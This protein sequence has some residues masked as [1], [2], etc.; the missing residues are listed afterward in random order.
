M[1]FPELFTDSVTLTYGE[2]IGD[3]LQFKC[4]IVF[5]IKL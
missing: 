4:K 2:S 1:K 3:L 5:E